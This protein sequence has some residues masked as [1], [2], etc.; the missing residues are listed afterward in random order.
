MT[1]D[2][3]ADLSKSGTIE[4]DVSV[5]RCGL[6]AQAQTRNLAHLS[7]TEAAVLRSMAGSIGTVWR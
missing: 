6:T 3:L 4:L 5:A 1:A 7:N 2:V